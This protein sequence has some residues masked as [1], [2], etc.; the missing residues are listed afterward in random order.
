MTSEAMRPQ[1]TMAKRRRRNP[2]QNKPPRQDGQEEDHRT[3]C[4]WCDKRSLV[5]PCPE[6]REM[7]EDVELQT[8]GGGGS[9]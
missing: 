6:C 5:S 3:R 2:W 9:A 8:E 1:K 4:G 7:L